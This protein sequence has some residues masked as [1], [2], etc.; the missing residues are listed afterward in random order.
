M[1][2]CLFEDDWAGNF[3]PLVETRPVY[4]LTCGIKTLAEKTLALFPKAEISWHC[5]PQL[6]GI[7]AEIIRELWPKRRPAVNVWP[8]EDYLFLN[9][10]LLAGSLTKNLIKEL[11]QPKKDKLWLAGRSVLAAWLSRETIKKISPKKNMDRLSEILL[12]LKGPPR[13]K[14]SAKLLE[15]NWELIQDNPAEIINDAATFY[16]KGGSGAKVH[17]SARFIK[18]EDVFLGKGCQ[19]YAG[20]VLDAR[21]GPIII[22][23]KALIEHNAIVYGPAYLGQ[24]SSLKAGTTVYGGTTIGPGCRIGGEVNQSVIIGFS[25]KAHYGFL[26]HS[27]IGQWCNLGAGTTNSNLKNNYGEVKIWE[28][29]KMVPSGQQFLGLIMGDYTKTAIG[30]LFNTGSVV[31]IGANVVGLT[32]PPK[33]TPNFSW[34][35]PTKQQTYKLSEFFK[36]AQLMMARRGQKLSAAQKKLLGYLHK[37]S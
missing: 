12:G 16:S 14:T 15:H 31:G 30:T 28:N 32:H 17:P 29:G 21:R 5:R 24:D 3:R 18:K 8:Q 26:G 9:G 25:N 20:A 2:V 33:F 13:L 37:Q 22:D 23:A 11:S 1:R 10:R 19:I 4:F 7:T 34:G 35:D 6:A 27:Y 36:T